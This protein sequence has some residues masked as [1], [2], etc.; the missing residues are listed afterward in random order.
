[1]KIKETIVVEGYHDKQAILKVVQAN[2][3]ITNGA[4]IKAKTIELI[5]A[6]QQSSGVIVFTDPD[7]PG[8]RLR[9]LL[10]D[11]I[12]GL[13]HA[14]LPQH[15]ARDKNKVG[16][17]HASSEHILLAL[18]NLYTLDE[19]DSNLTLNDLIELG[20]SGKPESQGRRNQVANSLHIQEGNAKHFLKQCQFKHLNKEDIEE[21]IKSCKNQ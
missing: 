12:P 19:Q 15:L 6:T 1:M 20:L 21:T 5:K 17:E 2:V 16:V 18:E 14:V 13:K 7:N 4:Q 3:I 11:K 8:K 10:D 9:A